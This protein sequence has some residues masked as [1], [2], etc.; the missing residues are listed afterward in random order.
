[1]IELNVDYSLLYRYFGIS[2]TNLVQYANKDIEEIMKIEAAQGN[3]KAREYK[4]IL[5]DPD[6]LVEIF[7]LA[8]VENRYIILQN[9]SEGDLDKILPFLTQEQLAM[10][11]NFFND[12]KLM[13]LVQQL[14]IEELAI[15]IFE[16]FSLDDV[17]EFMSQD[18]M[19]VFLKEPDVDRKYA[20]K[21]FESLDYP[22]LQKIMV[23]QFGEEYK[24]KSQ[25]EYLTQLEDMD[26]SRF[27]IF[28]TSL[29]REDKMALISGIASQDEDLLLLFSAKDLSRPME[30]LMKDDKIKMMSKLDP[31]FLVPMIQDLP[32]DLTQIVLTQIDPEVFS[33][34]LAKDFQNILSSVVLFSHGG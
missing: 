34:V 9:M 25:K 5:S 10:G 30:M 16:Q 33:K 22:T 26:D 21:Y 31:K 27:T 6:K 1:M 8:N 19:D 29:K 28:M 11:L 2:S 23:Q 18:T 24:D 14:P 7:K 13:M 4:K 20:Q 32:L 12:E 3:E 17:L 15:M